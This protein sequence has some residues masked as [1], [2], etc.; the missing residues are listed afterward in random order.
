MLKI[1][2]PGD[3]PPPLMAPPKPTVPGPESDAASSGTSK[4]RRRKKPAGSAGHSWEQNP[5]TSLARRGEQG[6]M[7]MMLIGGG[8]LFLFIVWL[9]IFL[10]KRETVPVVD[11][12][13]AARPPVVEADSGPNL[14]ALEKEAGSVARGFLDA[15]TVDELLRWV[16]NPEV[17][18]VRM[19]RFYPDGRVAAPGLS[20]FNTGDGL[21]REGGFHSF[22]VLT[23]DQLERTLAF[24]GTP[25]GLKVDWESWVGWSDIPWPEFIASKPAAGHV[26]RVL[27]APVDYYNFAFSDD[28]KWQCYRLESPDKEHAVF[29]YVEKDSS[30]D[31]ELRPNPGDT[32]TP[33][34]LALKFPPDPASDTQVIIER[35]VGT[36]WVEQEEKP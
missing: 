26:F 21:Q 22:R 24:V 13:P 9:V 11:S 3:N 31:L 33:V 20:Q 30:L 6:R 8:V 7:R 12:K 14:A 34:M 2:A 5:A 32:A 10:T 16:R 29:G 1:P 4:K 28:T 27:L 35:L 36:G 18:E 19:R 15:G 25:Q 23:G 17:A